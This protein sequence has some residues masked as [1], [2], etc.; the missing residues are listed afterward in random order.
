MSPIYLGSKFKRYIKQG[1][2]SGGAGYVLSREALRRLVEVGLLDKKYCRQDES[3][4]EDVEVGKCLENLNVTAGDSRDSNERG[5]MFPFVPE[6]HI[7]KKAPL[8]Y[9]QHLFYPSD[10]GRNCCSD[11]AI[12]FHYVNP[13]TMYT[14]EYL[15]Y[16]LKPV[17][18]EKVENLFQ[19]KSDEK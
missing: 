9:R 2:M 7:N 1:V 17:S 15:I 11:T 3:G 13:A 12:S 6:I 5:R 19:N 4:A 16:E 8:W 10:E 14:L 18:M